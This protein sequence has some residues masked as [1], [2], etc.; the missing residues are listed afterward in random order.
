MINEI[1]HKVPAPTRTRLEFYVNRTIPTFIDDIRVSFDA[2]ICEMCGVLW[3]VGVLTLDESNELYAY[4]RN[5]LYN[6]GNAR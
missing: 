2:T 6:G 1:L 3:D 4:Y 5:R